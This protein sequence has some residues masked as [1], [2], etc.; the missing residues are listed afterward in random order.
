MNTPTHTPETP[1]PAASIDLAEHVLHMDVVTE[2]GKRARE[3]ARK[4]LAE[5]DAATLFLRLIEHA[6]APS[7]EDGAGHENAHGLAQQGLAA[8]AFQTMPVD[9][10]AERERFEAH[11]RPFGYVLRRLDN[12]DY[13]DSEV[14]AVWSGYSIRA[15]HSPAPQ[16]MPVG[17]PQTESLIQALHKIEAHE[18]RAG[19]MFPQTSDEQERDSDAIRRVIKLLRF[20]ASDTEDGQQ[21]PQRG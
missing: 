7:P 21:Q 9:E 5:G 1:K 8:L 17:I 14:Q 13:F 19:A 10:A 4:V 6:T 3:L 18:R 20:Y 11:M 16:A 12:G 2:R 15:K